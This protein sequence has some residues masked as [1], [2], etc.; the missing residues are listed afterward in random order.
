M[1]GIYDIAGTSGGL[2]A[3]MADAY[4][5][6]LQSGTDP[7]RLASYM[8]ASGNINRQYGQNL[9]S[10]EQ[11]GLNAGARAGLSG[12]ALTTYA[13]SGLADLLM[14]RSNAMSGLNTDYLGNE[15]AAG[16]ADRQR[17]FERRSDL[18]RGQQSL[19]A[20]TEAD[21]R[22]SHGEAFK[23]F[24]DRKL[25]QAQQTGEGRVTN[26]EW[27]FWADLGFLPDRGDR[28]S[29]WFA[30]KDEE[31]GGGAGG[32]SFQHPIGGGQPTGPSPGPGSY[33]GQRYG[34]YVW[35]GSTWQ[36]GG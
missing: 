12:P 28:G 23:A 16:E 32:A 7:R 17:M 36:Y 3:G 35:D 31:I 14:S 18:L 34:P 22:A 2:P 21:R 4:R 24:L 26:E 33:P 13:R 11:G 20:S 9:R 25:T 15:A 19:Y 6:R 30:Q 8:A 27:D 1:P 29:P 5:Y 10:V